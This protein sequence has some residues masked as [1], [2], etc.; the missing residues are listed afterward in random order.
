MLPARQRVPKPD[1]LVPAVTEQQVTGVAEAEAADLGR[2]HTDVTL[3]S[4]RG[5][6]P[7]LD[8]LLPVDLEA[9]CQELS[10]GVPRDVARVFA[11]QQRSLDPAGVQ[12]PE[13][14]AVALADGQLAA[15]R[16][17]GEGVP[18]RPDREPLLLLAGGK[19][20]YPHF[21]VA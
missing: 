10:A 6:V 2:W 8:V 18:A 9:D 16:V 3:E 19:V 1:R 4:V 5:Y 11:L 7:D 21:S 12:V 20:V 15:I 17:P 14:G 13:L